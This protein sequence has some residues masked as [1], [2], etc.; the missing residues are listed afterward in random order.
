MSSRLLPVS[1]EPDTGLEPTNHETM[2]QAEI[3][4]Q[5]LNPAK[6]LLRVRRIGAPGWL[7]GLSIRLRLRSRSQG[8]CVRAPLGALVSWSQAQ[9]CSAGRD[10]GQEVTNSQQTPEAACRSCLCGVRVGLL[11]PALGVATP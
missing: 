10:R 4:S 11:T 1:T 3:E 5:T 2:T 7:S 9:L 6:T 8:S